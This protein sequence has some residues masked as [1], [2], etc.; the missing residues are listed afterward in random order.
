M[1]ITNLFVSFRREISIIR[2]KSAILSGLAA[3]EYTSIPILLSVITLMLTGQSLAPVNVFMLLMFI[4]LLRLQICFGIAYGVVETRESFA[5]LGRI[6]D[7]LI[8]EDLFSI[9]EDHCLHDRGTVAERKSGKL[10]NDFTSMSQSHVSDEDPL[11][12]QWINPSKPGNVCVSHLTYKE[13]AR[14]DEF[15]LQDVD[16][17]AAS[18]SLTVVTGPVGS[19][20]STLLSAIAGEISDVG[21][22]INRQGTFVYAPQIPWVFSGT[23]RENILFGESY[24][25]P[26]YTR[27]IGACALTEDFQRFPNGDQTVVGERGAVLSGGQRARV[28]L[29]RAVYVDADLY[30]LDDPLSAVDFKVGRHIFEKCIKGLLGEKTRLLTSHQEQHMKYERCRPSDCTAQRSHSGEGNLRRASRKRHLKYH[31]RPTLQE[32]F[33]REQV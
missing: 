32:C 28:S 12:D 27:I 18:G 30:L 21:G 4:N 3:L 10:Q 17:V 1:I 16:F 26:R 14:K 2:K 6:E 7:F 31:H 24:D 13:V 5:S 29:A 19:G 23:L 33:D 15:I 22:T 9:S 8:S 11:T 25:E 20:K